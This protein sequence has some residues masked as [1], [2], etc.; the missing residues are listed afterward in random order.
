MRKLDKPVLTVAEIVRNAIGSIA[1]PSRV[2]RLKCSSAFLNMVETTYDVLGA[3]G[4]L[5]LIPPTPTTPSGEQLVVE[6]GV[7]GEDMRWLYTSKLCGPPSPVRKL[8]DRLI[9]SARNRTCPLCGQMQVSTLDH[10][11]PQSAYPALTIT[12]FNLIPACRDCNSAKRTHS[13]TSPSQRTLHPYYDSVDHAQ[14][15]HARVH[16]ATPPSLSFYVEVPV[17]WT[18]QVAEQLHFHF[19]TLKLGALFATHAG[20]ELVNIRYALQRLAGAGGP[21]AVR[22]HLK[23]E[24]DSRLHAHRN[25]WQ[26]ATYVAL[27][28]S[29]WFCETGFSAID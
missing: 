9:A 16:E 7:T 11:L 8:Y 15:L 17:G 23:T 20:G 22:D 26:A 3:T 2:N 13:P 5:H 28:Q 6:S 29:D 10:Y 12:P 27:S 21:E 24:A 1:D 19:K 14:W 25:S 18:A 4:E